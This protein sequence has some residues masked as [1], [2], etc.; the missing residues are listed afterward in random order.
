MVEDVDDEADEFKRVD[1][2]T[3]VVGVGRFALSWGDEFH[4]EPTSDEIVL[5]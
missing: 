4:L 3:R 2:E 5:G 1:V